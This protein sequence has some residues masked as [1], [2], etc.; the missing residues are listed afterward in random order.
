LY[1]N[2]S[3]PATLQRCSPRILPRA[4]VASITS[5][6]FWYV[7]VSSVTRG[8]SGCLG[9]SPYLDRESGADCAPEGSFCS[10][11][12]VAIGWERSRVCFSQ[13]V[14]PI[15]HSLSSCC[16][17]LLRHCCVDTSQLA[18]RSWVIHPWA[19][20]AWFAGSFGTNSSNSKSP[21][22]E[23]RAIPLPRYRESACWLRFATTMR[24]TCGILSVVVWKSISPMNA[25]C[26][27]I[28]PRS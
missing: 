20:H 22:S 13:L 3:A 21:P 5:N 11:E 23:V 28:K 8:P 4:A 17:S 24:V 14:D 25:P 18:H 16:C 26:T 7:A 6:L 15:S 9:P 19:N 1:C 27:I 10:F 12:G 2:A